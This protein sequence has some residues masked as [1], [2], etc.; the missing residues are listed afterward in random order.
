MTDALLDMQQS[1]HAEQGFVLIVA[2]KER[3]ATLDAVRQVVQAGVGVALLVV[4]S[5]VFKQPSSRSKPRR[6]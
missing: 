1:S 5:T 6:G 2:Q 3:Q 4:T